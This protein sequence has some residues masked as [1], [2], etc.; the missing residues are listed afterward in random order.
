MCSSPTNVPEHNQ[1]HYVWASVA[2]NFHSFLY[3]CIVFLLKCLRKKS[4][5]ICF[6][7]VRKLYTFKEF[8]SNPGFCFFFSAIEVL[9]GFIGKVLMAERYRWCWEI[10]G[11]EPRAEFS[12]LTQLTQSISKKKK[13]TAANVCVCVKTEIQ[14]TVMWSFKSLLL[15]S[16]IMTH[17]T[18]TTDQK[19]MLIN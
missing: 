6:P 1:W 7:L 16:P 10:H 12:K 4:V 3:N 2:L 14:Y 17:I 9:I 13:K 19:G 5:Q 18:V 8:I 15:T 11:I